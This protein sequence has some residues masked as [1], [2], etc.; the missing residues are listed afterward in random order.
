MI[1]I[2]LGHTYIMYKKARQMTM[3]S[4]KKPAVIMGTGWF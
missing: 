3:T 4:L 2:S 1:E